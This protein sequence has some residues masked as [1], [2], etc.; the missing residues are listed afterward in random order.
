MNNENI[1][2]ALGTFLD[3]MRPFLNSESLKINRNA[4]VETWATGLPAFTYL[5]FQ[6]I[7]YFNVDPDSTPL[8]PVF[9]STVGLKDSKGK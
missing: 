6:R 5:Q 4:F 2:Q 1:Y 9:N 8:H 3:A 7:G